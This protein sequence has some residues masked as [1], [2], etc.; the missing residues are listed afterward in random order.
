[1]NLEDVIDPEYGLQQDEW[2]LTTPTFGKDNQL[3]V[4]GWSGKALSN[5]RYLVLCSIC[6][7]D[8]EIF[9]EGYFKITKNNLIR[10]RIPCGCSTLSQISEEH[11]RILCTRKAASMGY[12]FLG[13]PNGWNGA[14]SKISL[15]CA[16]HGVWHSGSYNVFTSEKKRVGCPGC[17]T[18]K[19]LELKTKVFTKEEIENLC[20]KIGAEFNGFVEEYKGVKTKVI[21]T[22]IK[23]KFCWNTTQMFGLIRGVAGCKVCLAEERSKRQMMDDVTAT[24]K[25]MESGVFSPNTKFERAEGKS[26]WKVFCEDCGYYTTAS[27]SNLVAGKFSCCCDR[28]KQIYSYVFT[29]VDNGLPIA[30][31]F[32]ITKNPSYRLQSQSYKSIFDIKSVGVWRYE[33]SSDCRKAENECRSSVFCGVIDKIGMPD[34]FTETTYPNNIDKII[35]IYE[36]NGGVRCE[37][38]F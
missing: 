28:D 24:V 35:E 32:G 33:N 30:I 1:M 31:K 8:P 15:L 4:V 26:R 36:R 13:F 38:Q 22:C 16:E 18:D 11:A 20:L 3:T 5:K 10:G 12:E 27:H 34:G 6:K 29:I 2:S 19:L 17:K 9:G 37:D 7:N 14:T 23:H 21:L 25:F